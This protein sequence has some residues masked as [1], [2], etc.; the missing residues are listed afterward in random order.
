MKNKNNYGVI[1]AGGVGSRFW[2]L[3]TPERPKQF[4]DVLGIGKSLIRMT[5]DRLAQIAPAENIYVMTNEIYKQL[6]IDQLPDINPANILT[7]PQRKNTAPCIAYAASRIYTLNN[8]ANLIVAPSDHLIL[9]EEKFLRILQAALDESEN[10]DCLVTLGIKPNRPD[11]G[12][13]YIQFFEAGDLI[14]GSVCRVKQFTEKPNRELAEIFLKSGDYYWNSGIFVWKAKTILGALKKFKPDLYNL[15]SAK[16]AV[17]GTENE[18]AFVNQ[19]FEKCEDISIDF[20]VME[21]AKNVKVVLSDF[22][23]S[24]LGTWGSVY[25]HLEKDF[26]G[27]AA[28]GGKAQLIE[29]ENCIVNLPQER[30][31]LIQGLKDYIIVEANN[32]LLILSKKDEQKL[33]DYLKLLEE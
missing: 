2:P 29:S 19:C 33:K 9:Q 6:V 17:Y 4:L 31:A 22:D 1:M 18:Q 14:A 12:Y 3:S 16:S 13:G 26:N 23:W 8:D 27:N 7:E 15:F 21:N 32:K 11:T 24:D 20:A 5:F 28:I 30:T 10:E 25:A